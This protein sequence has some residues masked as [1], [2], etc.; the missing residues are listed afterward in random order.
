[1]RHSPGREI[2]LG[3][4]A[5]CG[6]HSGAVVMYRCVGQ[7]GQEINGIKA[8]INILAT[9]EVCLCLPLFG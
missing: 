8:A 9:E 3:V 4:L 6:S 1:M 2:R 5:L 7:D